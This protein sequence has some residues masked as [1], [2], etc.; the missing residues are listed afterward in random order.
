MLNPVEP[1]Q[2]ILLYETL[3]VC[4]SKDKQICLKHDT[5]TLHTVQ[6]FQVLAAKQ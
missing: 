6:G 4:L 2:L 5:G 1:I 3:I